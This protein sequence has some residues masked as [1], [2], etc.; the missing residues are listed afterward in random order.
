MF[1]EAGQLD[2]DLASKNVSEFYNREIML[3]AGARLLK[4]NGPLWNFY[5]KSD[6]ENLLNEI[7]S[8]AT[9]R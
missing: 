6:V 9:S 5:K 4:R 1:P 7:N 8:S 2:E 3:E